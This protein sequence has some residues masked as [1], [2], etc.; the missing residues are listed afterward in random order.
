MH[1]HRAV[2]RE[3]GEIVRANDNLPPSGFFTF[4]AS[5]YASS[6]AVAVRRQSETSSRVVSLGRLLTEIAEDA[7]RLTR[8]PTE[9]RAARPEGEVQGRSTRVGR[10]R[11][12]R[13]GQKLG[14]SLSPS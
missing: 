12:A 14:K 4:L 2:Y 11:P 13:G 5:T 7:G 8:T 9:S 1:W 6:Q 3:V 10:R